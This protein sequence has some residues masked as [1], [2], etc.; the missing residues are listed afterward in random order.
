MVCGRHRTFNAHSDEGALQE[1]YVTIRKDRLLVPVKGLRE[2]P[3]RGRH[4]NR[5]AEEELRETQ[6]ILRASASSTATAWDPPH[7]G[8][9]N[10]RNQE[11]RKET[12]PHA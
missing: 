11:W 5:L 7:R 2:A 8:M 1:D 10:L 4:P 12:E 9:K 3:Y 6:R